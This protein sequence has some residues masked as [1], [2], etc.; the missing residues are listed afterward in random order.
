[1]LVRSCIPQTRTRESALESLS[2]SNC[3]SWS[4]RT[5]K[6]ANGMAYGQ[7]IFNVGQKPE[8]EVTEVTGYLFSRPSDPKPVPKNAFITR[9]GDIYCGVGYYPNS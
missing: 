5:L 4:T 8:G 1:M 9:V 7:E 2:E 3:Q 6:D